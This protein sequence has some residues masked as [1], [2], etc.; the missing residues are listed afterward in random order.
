ML[1]NTSHHAPESFSKEDGKKQLQ[2]LLEDIS[3]LQN[4]LMAEREHA[5]LVVIQGMDASGKDGLIRDVFGVM[6]PIGLRAIS[7]K[8]PTEEEADHDFL[9][10]I[11]QHT[12]AKGEVAVFNRSHYEDLIV[13]AIRETISDKEWKSRVHSV[14]AFEEHLQQ[15]GAIKIL[16]FYM[17]VSHKKQQERLEERMVVAEKMWK[18]NADDLV[19]S[20]QWD[21]YM[22]VYDR[23]FKECNVAPWHIIPADQNWYK[24][25]LVAQEV[26]ETL[27]G[28]KMEFP[29]M[30]KG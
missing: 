29:G 9:W 20:G 13:P 24:E 8:V 12:P 28:L 4:L 5:L 17:H 14:N 2:E 22:K 23:I 16:K 18:Y 10:R 19:E 15:N 7:F 11:H 21:A 26:V 1:K 6:N 30:K 3:D 25:L 27:R